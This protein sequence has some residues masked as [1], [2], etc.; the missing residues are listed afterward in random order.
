MKEF[1]ETFF[2]NQET[3]IAQ[4]FLYMADFMNILSSQDYQKQI[5]TCMAIYIAITKEKTPLVE[6]AFI[7]QLVLINIRNIQEKIYGS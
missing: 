4:K 7:K 6:I 3:E 2:S 5:E 1:T